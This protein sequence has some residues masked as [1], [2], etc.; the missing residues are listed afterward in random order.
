MKLDQIHSVYMLGIGG[1]GMSAIARYFHRQGIPVSG[2]DKTPSPLTEEL[3]SEGIPVYFD[4]D[5][6]REALKSDL[7]MFTPAIPAGNKEMKAAR[8]AGKEWKKR[9]EVLQAITDHYPTLA[10]AGT[11]GKTTTSAMLSHLLYD[12]GVNM[13]GFVGG[14]MTNYHSNLICSEHVEFIVAEADEYDRSFH[15][16]NPKIAAIT[17]VDPDHLDIYG[18]AETMLADFQTFA[19]QVEDLLIVHES[20]ETK[21]HHKNKR[22]YGMGADCDYRISNLT[23]EDGHFHFLLHIKDGETLTLE[24]L[25]PGKHNAENA[26]AAIAVALNQGVKVSVLEASM[27]TFRGVKR[28]FEHVLKTEDV[29]VI[30]DYAHHPTEIE[31]AIDATRALYPNRKLTVVFQPHLFSRTRD[32]EAGFAESLAM[33]DELLL[34]EIYPAREEPIAGVSSAN[35]LNK[36]ALKTKALVSK[37]QVV[38]AVLS[39]TPK[40]V[41][42]LGA[43][44]IDRLVL[45]I[46]TALKSVGHVE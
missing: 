42:V 33:A 11:H 41:L 39:L 2:Y 29:I 23:V 8:A 34:L 31:A 3:E 16:L 5:P 36:V 4:E 9:S 45:P 40:T 27:R 30:D 1:I 13:A 21:I 37:A 6:E 10:I 7:L 32:L 26:A 17:S 44:D 19:N 46:A 12:G 14:V 20:I 22:T 18:D 28:R 24:T 43:G 38:N 35:L 25:M 15:R